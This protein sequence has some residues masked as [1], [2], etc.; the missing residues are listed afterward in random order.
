MA[1]LELDNL[2][3]RYGGLVA[4]NRVTMRVDVGEVRAVIGPNGAGKT[5]L[6]HLIT[7]VVRATEGDV[8]FN[9]RSLN[10]LSPYRICQAGLSRTFQ[11]TA[12]FPEM[13]ARENTRLSAQARL[14]RRW[15]PYGGG[16]VFA[17]AARRGDEAL[18]RL[19]LTDVARRPAGLLSHGDQRLLEVAMALAQRPRI[20][21]LDEP[22]QGLSVEETLSAVETL[23]GLLADGQLTVLLVEHDMEVV[24]RLARK[25]TVLHR[26]SVIAD[27]VPEVVKA[28]AN[29]QAAYLGGYT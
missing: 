18:E 21:L 15:Q 2:T 26:G 12:L 4:V 9:G 24:F 25:I 23:S 1:L 7:G 19:G 8:R 29:V 27:D 13:T 17:E 14:A 6:F 10:G 28:D 3:K 5:S 16:S 20:L 22:T 11:L